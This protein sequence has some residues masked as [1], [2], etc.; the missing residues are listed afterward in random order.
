MSERKKRASTGSLAVLRRGI[1]ES[2]D[3]RAG[4]KN[5]ILLG[6]AMTA[7]RVIVP[8]LVQQVLDHGLLGPEGFRPG[9]VVTESLIAAAIIVFVYF[10]ARFTYGRM[11]VASEHSLAAVRIRGFA[12]IHALSMAEQTAGRRGTFVS[13]VTADVDVIG[14]FLE[15]GALSWVTAPT[16][17]AGAAVSSSSPAPSQRPTTSNVWIPAS[18]HFLKA[19]ASSGESSAGLPSSD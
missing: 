1:R 3:L 19:Q 5:T 18:R 15:W 14:Q 7:G 17:M 12:H 4:L 9:F 16:L 13:R 2:D 8:V 11:V 6:I 10:A